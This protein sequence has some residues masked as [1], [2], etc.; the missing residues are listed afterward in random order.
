MSESNTLTQAP[1][2]GNATTDVRLLWDPIVHERFGERCYFVM[3]ALT[4]PGRTSLSSIE[5]VAAMNGIRCCSAYLVYGS[6][7]M[8]VRLWAT[9]T[10]YARFA[11]TVRE[12]GVRVLDDFMAL[13]VDYRGWADQDLSLSIVDAAGQQ[14]FINKV[15]SGTTSPSDARE[16]LSVLMEKRLVHKIAPTNGSGHGPSSI[17]IYIGL[18]RVGQESLATDLRDPEV[19]SNFH[20]RVSSVV[21]AV[22]D[23]SSVSVYYG[24]GQFDCI[25]KAVVLPQL[26]GRLTQ[27]IFD[28]QD[29]LRQVGLPVRPVTMIVGG[30]TTL[31]RDVINPDYADR[32]PSG[33]LMASLVSPRHTLLVS[34]VRDPWGSAV[35]RVFDDWYGQM[36]GNEAFQ[37]DFI[38][39]VESGLSSSLDG[40]WKACTFAARLET[41]VKRLVSLVV[42]PSILGDK[43]HGLILRSLR[44][45][46]DKMKL[47]LEAK[48]NDP[49]QDRNYRFC[50]RMISELSEDMT[51][52]SLGDWI[53]VL[54]RLMDAG[55]MT[56][57]AVAEH[58]GEGWGVWADELRL[59]RNAVTHPEDFDD[60]PAASDETESLRWTKLA[61]HALRVAAGATDRGLDHLAISTTTLERRRRA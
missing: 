51:K 17:K 37:Q 59:L 15:C 10:A 49:S 33:N 22:D 18:K 26:F 11:D 16:A 30:E 60:D 20:N 36:V 32:G 61:D 8:L 34:T 29:A 39:I 12:D 24:V 44:A 38:A 35:Y 3:L 14:E 1:F 25:V 13:Q 56:E 42:V 4:D 45:E 48:S 31:E 27:C 28:I 21:H 46:A 41:R 52:L 2:I 7:D 9:Q 19:L 57:P 54:S 23:L 50:T 40:L 47:E 58:L 53:G 43:W 6:Y 5:S 55:V